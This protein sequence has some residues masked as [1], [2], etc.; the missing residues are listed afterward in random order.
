MIYEENGFFFFKTKVYSHQLDQQK[1]LSTV[2]ISELL[3]EA[4]GTHANLF[5][6]GYKDV[7]KL[8][9]VWIITAMRFEI[10]KLPVWDEEITIKTWIVD[11]NRYFSNR[12]FQIM[13]QNGDVLISASTNWLLFNFNTRRPQLISAMNFDVNLHPELL[14]VNNAIKTDK[15][16]ISEG[17]IASIK[18]KYSDLD[19][20]GHMNNTRYFRSI[21]DS[22]SYDF[23]KSHSLKSFEIQFRNE[24]V[25]GDLLE[26]YTKKINKNSFHHEIKRSKDSKS[27]CYCKLEWKEK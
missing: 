13:N 15:L 4:A 21:V 10:E 16:S 27:N 17:P 26:I 9:L 24:A 6:F 12:H 18:V 2:A 23:H 11:I 14:S 20:V 8:D 19:M 3:Q 25:Y 5:G 22:Y 1:N 7:V